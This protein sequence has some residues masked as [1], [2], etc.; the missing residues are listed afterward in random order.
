MRHNLIYVS[1]MATVAAA[2]RLRRTAWGDMARNGMR[3]MRSV[4]LLCVTAFVAALAGG[5]ATSSSA[6]SPYTVNVTLRAH[7]AIE[8]DSDVQ[9]DTPCLVTTADVTEVFN[10]EAHVLAAGIDDQ[11]NFIEPLHVEQARE[12]SLQIVPNDPALPTYTGHSTAQFTNFPSSPNTVSTNTITLRGTDGSHLLSH[13]N[14][15]ILVKPS[16]ITLFVDNFHVQA[17]CG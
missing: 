17:N 13:E 8:F 2:L 12:E 11:G 3:G 4:R 14:I 9:F 6:D 16:G 15:H 7:K 1:V 5:A 10:V